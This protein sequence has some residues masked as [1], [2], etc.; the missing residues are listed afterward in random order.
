MP[1]TS[2][3][4]VRTAVELRALPGGRTLLT[5]PDG[6]SFR[7]GVTAGDAL[8][9]L[10]AVADPHL[11]SAALPDGWP[12]AARALAELV[13]GTGDTP[14]SA[15]GPG[16]ADGTHGEAADRGGDLDP[17]RLP[18]GETWVL[19]G[20]PEVVAA[21][22]GAVGADEQVE[23][24]TGPLHEAVHRAFA[25]RAVLL[26]A[27]R[28]HA[29]TTFVAADR[30]CADARV[31]WVPVVLER[32]R[33]H[34]GPWVT[35]GVGVSYEDYLARRIA[36]APDDEVER[37][38]LTASLTGDCGAPPA[39]L[40][41]TVASAVEHLTSDARL[42]GGDTVVDLGHG[43]VAHHPVLPLPGPHRTHRDRDPAALAD[44]LTGIVTRVRSIRHHPSVPTS[45]A[46]VQADVCTMRRVSRWANSTSCQGSAFDDPA[47]ARAAA[48]GEAV[49]RYCGN[50]LDTLP[51]EHASYTAL[52]RRPVGRVLDPADLVLYSDAQHAAPGFPFERLTP[53]LPVHWVPGRSLT[54]DEPVWVPASLVYVNWFTAGYSAAPV[55][56]FCPFAGIAAGPTLEYAVMSAL[57]EV[58]ERHATMVWWLNGHPLD[59]VD[60]G[61]ELDAVWSDVRRTHAQRPGL[62]ALDNEFGVPVAAGVLWNDDDHLLN[63]GFSA[64]ADLR[65]AAFK[66]WTEALTLQEGSRDLLA[67][68][69]RHWGAMHR[70]ALNGRSFKP[71]RADRRYLDDFRPDMHDCD[72]LMVQQQVHLDPRALDRV[73]P[74]VDT[75]VRRTLADVPALPA[76][77]LEHY[78]AATHALGLE[79]VVVDIT[80]ADVAATGLRVVRVIVPG[81][82][83]NAPAAFPFLGKG[84]VQD[85]AVELGWRTT[86]LAEDELNHFPLPHA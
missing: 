36:A 86:A 58:I 54:H 61:P 46:T 20:D 38:L 11:A 15:G 6:R 76:R 25:R 52:R 18:D 7:L 30:A 72:D 24:V 34:L 16:D 43:P 14:D 64:R 32:S 44:P 12:D 59:A 57:E 77:S 53:D 73:R 75:P 23:V 49:E 10:D 33:V 47:Q 48:L 28:G 51:V 67:Q 74:L 9:L 63:I 85:L 62:I 66:S 71:W 3:T 13:A 37:A 5:T 55:T 79:V 84:R 2:P 31:P 26:V 70:G 29:A 8:R 81:T 50:M 68:D 27:Q 82:V 19:H 40:G 56:N 69:G 42:R 17:M 21:L 80:S 35:P 22:V 65:S 45:L 83:G 1:S 39:A 4:T 78:L 41:E 60:P